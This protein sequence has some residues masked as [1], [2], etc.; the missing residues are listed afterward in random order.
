MKLKKVVQAETK[1][2]PGEYRNFPQ[3]PL[4]PR[5]IPAPMTKRTDGEKPAEEPQDILPEA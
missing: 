5:P 1:A 4:M 2:P 3:V